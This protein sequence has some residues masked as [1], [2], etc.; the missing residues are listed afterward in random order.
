M[1]RGR[2][3]FSRFCRARKHKG[4]RGGWP[5]CL[6]C[7]R[8]DSPAC[9]YQGPQK[10]SCLILSRRCASFVTTPEKPF[11]P[12]CDLLLADEGAPRVMGAV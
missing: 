2:G 6:A 7:K 11:C 8:G 4:H 10:S 12:V 3:R 1:V 5:L 9:L